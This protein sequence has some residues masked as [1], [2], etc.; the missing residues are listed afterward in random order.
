VVRDFRDL[1]CWQ[2]AH[3][4][5]CEVLEFTATGPASRDFK[6]CDQIRSSSA[7]APGNIAEAFGHFGPGDAARFCEYAIASLHETLNHLID[8]RDRNYLS[9]ALCS[10]L[11]NLT[12]SALRATRNWMFYLKRR[13]RN[14][15]SHEPKGRP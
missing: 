10:R 7:S 11:S 6:Y 3:A 4:L 12:R 14:R 15:G 1:V 9:P 5:K 2:L 13:A 8:G